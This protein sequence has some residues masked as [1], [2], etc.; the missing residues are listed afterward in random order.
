MC[1][2]WQL[3]SISPMSWIK[4]EQKKDQWRDAPWLTFD[5]GF[6]TFRRHSPFVF[7]I[8]CFK[9]TLWATSP[10]FSSQKFC[11]NIH[12]WRACWSMLTFMKIRRKIRFPPF[13]TLLCC[14]ISDYLAADASAPLPIYGV[15]A[16][17]HNLWQ[18]LK[19]S[20]VLA[21]AVENVVPSLTKY[22]EVLDG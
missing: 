1:P 10:P 6:Q 21:G 5:Q 2:F 18:V 4:F 14:S 16:T 17:Y 3:C 13:P 7:C 8:F 22:F 20:K 11:W 12:W 9:N 15:V 19:V